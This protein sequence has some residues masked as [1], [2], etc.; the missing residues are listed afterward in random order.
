MC[1]I[2]WQSKITSGLSTKFFHK[3]DSELLLIYNVNQQKLIMSGDLSS[4]LY[5]GMNSPLNTFIEGVPKLFALA[6]NLA[7]SKKSTILIQSN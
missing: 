3:I 6:K 4:Q 5:V 1:N 2:T 7:I